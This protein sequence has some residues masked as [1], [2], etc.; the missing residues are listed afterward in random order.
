MLVPVLLAGLSSGS[1]GCDR[2]PLDKA[3]ITRITPLGVPADLQSAVKKCST[4]ILG[5]CNPHHQAFVKEAFLLA[6]DFKSAGRK[7]VGTFFNAG[8]QIRRDA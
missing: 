6:A 8:F 7:K 2:F 3:R 5:I 1:L 4:T